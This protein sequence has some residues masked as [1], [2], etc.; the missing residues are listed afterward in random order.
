M[1]KIELQM[2]SAVRSR[3][4]WHSGNTSVHN[5][6]LGVVIRLH[7][8]KIALLNDHHNKLIITDAGYQTNTTK[9]RLNALL[10]EFCFGHR[11]Q[12]INFDWFLI[13]KYDKESAPIA[14]EEKQAY[15]VELG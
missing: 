11:I 1:R 10:G 3:Q 4:D 13:N 5:S 12:A 7:G 2:L 8:S 14:I 6:E 9:S 15:P